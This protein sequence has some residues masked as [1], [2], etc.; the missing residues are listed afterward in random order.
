M[1]LEQGQDVQLGSVLSD[2]LRRLDGGDSNVNRVQRFANNNF[3]DYQGLFRD[4]TS[5]FGAPQAMKLNRLQPGSLPN[6]IAALFQQLTDD[7]QAR[8]DANPDRQ[9]QA[10]R[11][12]TRQERPLGPQTAQDTPGGVRFDDGGKIPDFPGNPPVHPPSPPGIPLVDGNPFG[13]GEGPGGIPGAKDGGLQPGGPPN[14]LPAQNPFGNGITRNQL[15]LN[16]QLG[17]KAGV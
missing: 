17:S 12:S 1:G 10:E 15:G 4:G 7:K 14:Q 5:V 11:F 2:R 3:Q 16:N 9:A 13:N 6:A 8:L